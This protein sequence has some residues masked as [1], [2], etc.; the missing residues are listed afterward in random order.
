M[1]KQRKSYAAQAYYG[2]RKFS[3][4]SLTMLL[5]EFANVLNVTNSVIS[6][7]TA[8]SSSAVDITRKQRTSKEKTVAHKGRK[9]VQSAALTAEASIQHGTGDARRIKKKASEPEKRTR[10]DRVNL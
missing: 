8:K 4:A 10:I 7:N 2:M 1:L 9:I 6:R 5:S 3:T